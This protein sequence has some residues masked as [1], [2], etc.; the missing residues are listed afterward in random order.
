VT[1]AQKLF[2]NDCWP[3]GIESNRTTLEAFL[4]YCHEQG[5]TAREVRLEEL[6]L[7]EVTAFFKT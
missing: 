3:Y 6:F 7:R 1:E 5:V 2:G 4:Q